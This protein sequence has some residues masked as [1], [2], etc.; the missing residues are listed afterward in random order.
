LL[1]LLSC[2]RR[3]EP[4]L[5]RAMRRID[6]ALACDPGLEAQL[7][8]CHSMLE[9]GYDVCVWRADQV[10]DYRR[11]F[12][13]LA[14]S[15]QLAV[16]QV[17]QDI[18][19][20]R[21]RA[22]DVQE[23]LLWASHVAPDTAAPH[24]AAIQTAVEWLCCLPVGDGVADQDGMIAFAQQ[25]IAFHGADDGL[26]ARFSD[27]FGPLWGI[28][29][30][31]AERSGRRAPDPG[32]LPVVALPQWRTPGTGVT[33]ARP[34]HLQQLNGQLQ[35]QASRQARERA[36]SPMGMALDLGPLTVRSQAGGSAFSYPVV[37]QVHV[38]DG[39][40]QQSLMLTTATLAL[41]VGEVASPFG[42]AER[43]RDCYGLYADLAIGV[44]KTL[45]KQR[46]RYIEPG[47]FLMGS[48]PDER[49]RYIREG[50][51]HRVSI[52][53]GFWLA[54]TACTQQLWLAV[55]GKNPSEFHAKNKG[56]PQH[57]VENVSWDDIQQFLMK[58]Q[59]ILEAQ[60]LLSPDCKMSLPTEAEWEYACRAGSAGA[61]NFGENVN[62]DQVNY[63]GIYLNQD[64]GRNG[65][66]RRMMMPVKSFSRNAWG[67]Y[68]MHG[69]LG[70]WCHDG[71][72]KYGHDAVLNP[73]RD[74]GG[75]AARALRGGA[76]SSSAQ[77]ARSACRFG[78]APDWRDDDAG[79]RLACR[80]SSQ[81]SP[82]EVF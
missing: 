42:F 44:G 39:L 56:G 11:R 52:T 17:M 49:G 71:L 43:G 82:S 54:E 76:W 31:A 28:A 74:G 58:F 40:P 50:P 57:P 61:F 78:F 62:T 48:P 7:W 75:G 67:L 36:F 26:I 47:Q 64:A 19:A 79:F 38:G 25:T 24:A 37:D 65:K 63:D 45:I 12:A 13:A 22:I 46:M 21:G 4:Q 18:H 5:V 1:T 3:I 81:A 20:V 68:Q 2:A 16:L 10:Q 53:H 15:L 14:P 72:R 30:Q 27:A 35:L 33:T 59:L 69:N 60:Q 32:A 73:G 55:M 6:P 77:D 80:S 29:H 51:Q 34:Y 70:E 41:A 23:L 9:I 66:Y 8:S